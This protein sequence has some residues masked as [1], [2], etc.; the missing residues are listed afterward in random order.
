MDKSIYNYLID[1]A[2][3]AASRIMKTRLRVSGFLNRL[4]RTKKIGQQEVELE[5]FN[6]LT[7]INNNQ[8]I[9]NRFS[10]FK[11]SFVSFLAYAVKFTLKIK[12][13]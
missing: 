7:I 3:T 8:V 12:N 6:N 5:I 1:A 11:V 10:P 9:I 4:Y 2:S 13:Y